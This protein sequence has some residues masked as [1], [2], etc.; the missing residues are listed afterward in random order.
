[1]PIVGS[2]GPIVGPGRPGKPAFP[3]RPLD[4]ECMDPGP[5]RLDVVELVR[6]VVGDFDPET[7]PTGWEAVAQLVHRESRYS[8]DEVQAMTID[9]VAMFFRT[10]AGSMVIQLGGVIHTNTA[11]IVRMDAQPP[12]P[13]A[14]GRRGRKLREVSVKGV[15]AAL[16]ALAEEDPSAMLRSAR[17]LEDDATDSRPCSK[18]RVPY[19]RRTIENC[20]TYK[21]WR[22]DLKAV[23]KRARDAE[24][25][26]ALDAQIMRVTTRKPGRD[27]LI[28]TNINP[29]LER[30]GD[31][32]I[33][34]AAEH[35]GLDG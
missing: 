31:E 19:C 2:A 14:S 5:P 35:E 26:D 15:D 30:A 10:F 4:P 16:Q 27:R 22:R 1:M 34:N 20:E 6:R 11:T 12:T 3:V 23:R 9:D 21:G 7:D 24:V 25:S 17:E 13:S 18:G 32:W 28:D 8:R 29:D 33:R